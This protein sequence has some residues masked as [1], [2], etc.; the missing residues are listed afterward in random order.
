M[1]T[2][3]RTFDIAKSCEAQT[4]LCVEKDYPHFAPMDGRCYACHR[5]IYAEIDNGNGYKSGHSF[6]KAST[7]LITGCPHC[8]TSYCE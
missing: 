6:E 5:N 3:T 1:K 2:E 7:G 8:H 4:K